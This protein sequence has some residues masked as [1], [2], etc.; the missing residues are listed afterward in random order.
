LIAE[1][2]KYQTKPSNLIGDG[3][4]QDKEWFLEYTRQIANTKAI[5]IG[6]ILKDYFRELEQEP[7]DLI[8]HDETE[9]SEE[10]GRLMF[11]WKRREAKYR[12]V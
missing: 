9:V 10:Q 4:V 12:L 5:S 7:E 6:G 1:V 2:I 3:S 11:N 8:G